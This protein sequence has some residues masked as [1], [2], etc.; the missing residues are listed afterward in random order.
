MNKVGGEKVLSIWMFLIFG[1]IALAVFVM[2][3]MFYGQEFDI[4]EAQAEVLVLRLENCFSSY[5]EDF[6]IDS[7]NIRELDEDFY[8]SV[9]V[10][11][12]G[13]LI[14]EYSSGSPGFEVECEL[15]SENFAR[16]SSESI[17]VNGFDIEILAGSN[18]LGGRV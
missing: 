1:V 14:E 7:C 10:Y 17:S 4:R 13:E 2:V 11:G 9:E 15:P 18:F 6:L 8:F 12:E 16:C 3:S 5:S